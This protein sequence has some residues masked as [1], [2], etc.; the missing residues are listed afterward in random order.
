MGSLESLLMTPLMVGFGVD[1]LSV[2]ASQLLSVRRAISRLEVSECQDLV[3]KIS[4]VASA[5][6][7]EE[8]CRA[9]AMEK[10]PELIS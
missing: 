2:G 4:G 7:V 1:E 8:L 10:Y 3:E 9:L 6:E 5:V